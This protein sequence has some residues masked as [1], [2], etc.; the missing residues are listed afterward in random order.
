MSLNLHKTVPWNKKATLLLAILIV[1]GIFLCIRMAANKAKSYFSSSTQTLELP[2][3]LK[4]AK[5]ILVKEMHLKTHSPNL[6]DNTVAWEPVEIY[7]SEYNNS[8][9]LHSGKIFYLK[10][11]IAETFYEA[12]SIKFGPTTLIYLIMQ[13]EQGINYKILYLDIGNNKNITPTEPIFQYFNSKGEQ[14]I[15]SG[16]LF[17]NYY[18]SYL[19]Y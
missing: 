10:T 18:N 19:K 2:Q 4:N 8:M 15:L 7:D 5:V 16:D 9:V 11:A 13:D 3:Q 1:L 17:Y 6:P 12:D 14:K